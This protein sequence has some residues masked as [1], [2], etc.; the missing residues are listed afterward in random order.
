MFR[1]RVFEESEVHASK[2]FARVWGP[3]MVIAATLIPC[4]S[5]L[6]EGR[7]DP[8]SIN[9]YDPREVA[10]LPRFCKFTQIFRDRVP[11]G[12]DPQELEQ[13]RSL[14]GPRFESLHHYCW[15]LMKTNRAM[16]MVHDGRLREFYLLD[17]IGEYDFVLE[18][19]PDEFI[20]LPE[21]LTKKGEN[22]VR[23]GRGPTA[24][25]QFER[26]IALKPDYWP[27]FAQLSDYYRELGDA[28]KAREA[29]VR[30]LSSAPDAPA[31]KRRLAELDA[32][33]D[34]RKPPARTAKQSAPATSP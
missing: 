33:G 34:A 22:L 23:L 14:I 15:G 4:A 13:W 24:V 29:L 27:P 9:A 18:R 10:L 2:L 30:G 17:A 21:I 28:R 11:G 20:L 31:L 6:A 8:S 25:L 26:A 7:D 19:A 1:D 16:L 12:N 5:S 3:A 32:G